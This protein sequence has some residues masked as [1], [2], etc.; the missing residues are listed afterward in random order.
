MTFVKPAQT[1]L[2]ATCLS[3]SGLAVMAVP[4]AHAQFF[5][6]GEPDLI[7]AVRKGDTAEVRALILKG[8]NPQTTD[9]E[10]LNGIAIA[11]R[12]A[13]F[14]MLE[15]LVQQQV[16]VN[17]PDKIGNTPLLWVSDSGDY[18]VAE[19]LVQNGA[20]PNIRNKRGLTPIMVAARG[21]YA[22]IVELL[23]DNGAD[24]AQR[25]YTGRSALDWARESRT[26][27]IDQILERAGAQ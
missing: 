2:L 4:D 6:S 5:V 9:F 22:D 24:L 25:D 23:V 16:N 11:A 27:G 1:L 14:T 10:G 26:P 20:D 7:Q 13:D 21:G 15:F 3:L 17:M 12:A 8:E 18:D 19:F